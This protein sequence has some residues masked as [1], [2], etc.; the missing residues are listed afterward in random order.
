M[1]PPRSLKSRALQLLAQR[2]QSRVE[3]RRKLLGRVADAARTRGSDIESAETSEVGST[4]SATAAG[5]L[6]HPLAPR[7]DTATEVDAVLDWL[8]AHRF[9]SAERFAESRINARSPRFGNLRIRAE[10]ARHA[11]EIPAEADQALL[12]SELPRARSVRSRK[13]AAAPASPA[14][15]A[16][17]FRFLSMRGFSSAVIRQVLREAV[18]T[19]ASGDQAEAADR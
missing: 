3:L 5:E 16:R 2:D 14:E 10:L 11:V 19:T 4:R 15:H 18:R 12:E 8:E 13:F 9:L 17:Q 1:K 6:D 7:V